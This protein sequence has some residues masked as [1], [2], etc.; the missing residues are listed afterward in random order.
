M[1]TNINFDKLS[2]ELTE[3]SDIIK[4]IRSTEEVAILQW[5]VLK[6]KLC[7]FYADVIAI[8]KQIYQNIDIEESDPINETPQKISEN[9]T[10]LNEH[11]HVKNLIPNLPQQ[12]LQLDEEKKSI[13]I[14]EQKP[15]VINIEPQT[16]LV[17]E[18]EQEIEPQEQLQQT[19][20][21][22]RPDATPPVDASIIH[23]E[24]IDNTEPQQQQQEMETLKN[25]VSEISEKNVHSF[26]HQIKIVGDIPVVTNNNSNNNSAAINENAEKKNSP[27][28]IF[29]SLQTIA[30]HYKDNNTTISINEKIAAQDQTAFANLN[31]QHGDLKSAIGINEKFLFINELFKGNM[32][33]YTDTIIGL[34][35]KTDLETAFQYLEPM[36]NKYNWRDDSVAYLTLKDFIKVR[37]S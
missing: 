14:E 3:I 9:T 5:D 4:D 11:E 30:D 25:A 18:Q 33:E 37:F 17:E 26:L 22:N 20:L 1:N 36:K 23:F 35:E 16:T 13:E 10:V 19:E 27:L 6:L 12:E 34:N 21:E 31:K 29:S 28:D 24:A 15:H 32:K 8:E 7:A 2:F